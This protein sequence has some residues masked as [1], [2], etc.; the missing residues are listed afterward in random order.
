MTEAASTEQV[1]VPNILVRRL[2]LR[3][4]AATWHAMREFNESRTADT[5]DELWL[6]QHPPV[7]TLGQAGK[8]EHIIGA[9]GDIPVLETD[10]GGQVTYHGPGQLILY[11]LVDLRR[12]A[13]GVR[14]LV[15]CLETA[16]INVLAAYEV[17]AQAHPRAPGVYVE[18]AKVAALGLRVRHGCAYHGL[19]LNVAMDLAPFQLID[20]CGYPGLAVTQ[21]SALGIDAGCVA[22]EQQ[23]AH[24]LAA[25]LGYNAAEP[26][27]E[28]PA[29]LRQ[30][31]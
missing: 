21:T 31:A 27:R 29:Q 11:V 24:E 19:S 18:D 2:G 4:Y 1:R 26:T 5:A 9:P 3:E 12:L 22:L 23:L 13:F 16:I 28:P 25:Q 20:P 10:R 17:E 30:I 6:L 14:R 15:T 8:R 7:F